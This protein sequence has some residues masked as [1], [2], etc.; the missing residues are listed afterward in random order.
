[1]HTW[2]DYNF[3]LEE[4]SYCF[5]KTMNDD[6]WWFMSIICSMRLDLWFVI[7]LMCYCAH[8]STTLFLA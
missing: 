1:M 8:L 7:V 2:E 3:K 4:G 6:F 5:K